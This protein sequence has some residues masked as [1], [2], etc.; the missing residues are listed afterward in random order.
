MAEVSARKTHTQRG[1]YIGLAVVLTIVSAIGVAQF[2]WWRYI[3]IAGHHSTAI[4]T[5]LRTECGNRNTVSYSF[6]ANG[7][8]Q[9][10]KD[11]WMGCRSLRPGDRIPVSF[12]SLDPTQN[13]AGNGYARLAIETLSILVASAAASLWIA[14]TFLRGK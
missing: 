12:S 6:P 1:T 2:G 11:S 9:E 14:F 13:I 4:G 5:V 8:A 10:G 3:T 7:S